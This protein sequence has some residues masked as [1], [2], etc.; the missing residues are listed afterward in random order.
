[1]S[2]NLYFLEGFIIMP[3][4][5]YHIKNLR[6]HALIA[7]SAASLM[8]GFS[9]KAQANLE[10]VSKALPPTALGA[11]ALD[12]NPKAW[13]FYLKQKGLNKM[14]MGEVIHEL[15]DGF[16]TDMEINF[17]DLMGGHVLLA[18][19]PNAK[20]SEDP[21]FLVSMDPPNSA[22]IQK[23]LEALK[24][25][26]KI[27]RE[28]YQGTEIYYAFK[29]SAENEATEIDFVLAYRNQTLLL[30]SDF[31]LMK[32]ALD[33]KTAD[34]GLLK[35]T[36]YQ[37][38][39]Q[40]LG[41]EPLILW[42]DLQ[43]IKASLPSKQDL[44]SFAQDLG[45]LLM[46]RKDWSLTSSLG[47]GL[48]FDA[49][50]LKTLNISDLQTSG[51]KSADQAYINQ[52]KNPKNLVSMDAL[53]GLLP[54]QPLVTWMINTLSLNFDDPDAPMNKISGDPE[55]LKIQ[56]KALQEFMQ[57]TGLDLKKDIL[58]HSDG[59]VAMS[60]FY[61]DRFPDYQ[62]APVFVTLLGSP[63]G[64]Q[65]LA[66]L[67]DKMKIQ[68]PAGANTGAQD[69]MLEKQAFETYRGVPFYT[70]GGNFHLDE[71]MEKEMKI[72][73]C[74]AALDQVLLIGSNPAGLRAIV[75]YSLGLR[76]PMNQ[77]SEFKRVRG[78]M[79]NQNETQLFYADLTRWAR[80]ADHFLHEEKDYQLFK[81]LLKS[82]K[83][84][85]SDSQFTLTGGFGHFL[86]DADLQAVNFS[87]LLESIQAEKTEDA[88]KL[89]KEMPDL[90]DTPTPISSPDATPKPEVKPTPKPEV[91]P[92]PKPEVKPTPKPEV[93]PTPKPEVKPTPKPEVKP[94]P[95]PEV[96]PTPKPEVKPTPKPEVKPT[97]KPEVKPTPK[98]EVKPTPKPEVKPTPKPEVK[99]TPTP[100]PDDDEDIDLSDLDLELEE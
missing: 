19:Y 85:A 66:H 70:L 27:H 11:M 59:R 92:T 67:Q 95:K 99:P 2:Q 54:P 8:M 73:I 90:E 52:V 30:G 94:T 72:K 13:D 58:A 61:L 100:T 74:F 71:A 83:A 98:P 4:Q 78:L 43:A 15:T 1:M 93:K 68:S 6:K 60:V 91:K 5:F 56:R 26:T 3:A 51:L 33:L 37:N 21:Y 47:M 86:V 16:K 12:L 88:D 41:K 55:L 17:Q 7:L 62:S 80:L 22:A 84:L 89:D 50:G 34:Q 79:N 65:F 45:P 23:S 69:F 82:L 49:Q 32:Q 36:G 75:D 20:S 57:E 53:L 76:S 31:A 44:A 87:E 77:D 39:F 9:G 24:S 35:N 63:N 10:T 18:L 28:T 48:H 97:P 29:E 38:V 46:F 40:R 42:A 64:P 96:K 25:H 14:L 81:P